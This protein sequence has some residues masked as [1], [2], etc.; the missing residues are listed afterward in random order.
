MLSIV[1]GRHRRNADRSR[2][3]LSDYACVHEVR[4]HDLDSFATQPGSES[5]EY[6]R[7]EA[8]RAREIEHLEAPRARGFPQIPSSM[9][10][11]D[12]APV[13]LRIQV[14]GHIQQQ[15]LRARGFQSGD[16]LQDVSH[17]ASMGT[18]NDRA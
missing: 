18:G 10:E 12:R 16:D 14:R 5:R 7:I 3:E 11:R 9:Q 17:G 13:P 4:M 2:R 8:I 1:P 6:P 15:N